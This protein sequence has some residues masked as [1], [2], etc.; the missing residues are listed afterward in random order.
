M[1]MVY[2]QVEKRGRLSV[3]SFSKESIK[4]SFTTCSSYSL[5]KLF[6]SGLGSLGTLPNS[7]EV[8]PN[9]WLLRHLPSML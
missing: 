6:L 8:L 2:K 3:T 9:Q 4:F 5:L 7:W 1:K